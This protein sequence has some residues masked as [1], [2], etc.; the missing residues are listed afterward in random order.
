M[1][2]CDVDSLIASYVTAWMSHRFNCFNDNIPS[3]TPSALTSTYTVTSYNI[4]YEVSDNALPLAPL[5]LSVSLYQHFTHRTEHLWHFRVHL[6]TSL[7]RFFHSITITHTYTH[8]LFLSHTHNLTY[9]HALSLPLS[10][11]LSPSLTHTPSHTL[12]LS[13][14]LFFSLS[15]SHTHTA[16]Y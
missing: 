14:S 16:N 7:S 15:L 9:T 13:L 8:C 12:S 6:N 3:S 10:L 2:L 1:H 5:P 11:F 4:T